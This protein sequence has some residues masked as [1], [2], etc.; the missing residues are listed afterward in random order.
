MSTE[1][2]W[3]SFS[4]NTDFPAFRGMTKADVVIIG[5][6][7]TGVTCAQLLKEQG[8][9]VIVL[10]ASK[11]GMSNT[12]N[13]TG[14]LYDLM[15]KDL[16]Q[17]RKK[18]HPD[19]IKQILDSRK[20]AVDFIED[21]VTKF[22]LDCDFVRVP[23]FYYT[24]IPEMEK[25]IE[26]EYNICQ[27]AGLDIEYGKPEHQSLN[28]VKSIR[29]ENQAQFNP[30]LYVQKLA[31]ILNDG[32][33][34]IYENTIVRNVTVKNEICTIE[35]DDGVIECSQVIHATHTPKGISAYHTLVEPYREYGISC[36]IRD[37]QHPAGIYFG[38]YNQKSIYSTRLY[39][40]NNEHYLI[41][42]GSPH[43]V[44]HESTTEHMRE[45]EEFAAK[46]FDVIEFTHR[47]GG[48]HYKPADEIPYIGRKGG[49]DSRIYV[50]TGFS[51]HGL[52][53]GVVAARIIKDQ[54]MG[55]ENQYEKLYSATRFTPVKSARNF[56]KENASVFYDLVKDYMRNDEKAFA[57][58]A[59]GEGKLVEH[60]GHRLA[61]YKNE[62]QVL[63]VCSAVC[64]HMGCL[65]RWND[66]ETSWDCPCHGSRF[67]TDGEVIEGPALHAL[68]RVELIEEEPK[69]DLLKLIKDN[70][71]T[72]QDYA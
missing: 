20:S 49:A 55:I 4:D 48:Q 17:I 47:W 64:T 37:P 42:V 52:V 50:A 70:F 2:I 23:W 31:K 72:G 7:M 5:A 26:K 59:P 28:A 67:A 51:T 9:K 38:Y 62:A 71:Q 36:K 63:S 65:V 68:P 25:Y 61:V 24:A 10:E 54:I 21:T 43:K 56:I 39:S 12:G 53:F 60:N 46:Q 29:V 16:I 41:V 1:S 6:G 58:I 40:R 3:Q 14:N 57:D 32:N 15:G 69:A 34:E 22:N 13:S 35:T 27:E 8:L 33:C 11:V 66:H 30:L 19:I 18:Y 44:G 45:L